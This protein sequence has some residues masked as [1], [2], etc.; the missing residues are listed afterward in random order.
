MKKLLILSTAFLMLFQMRTLAQN[1]GINNDGSQPDNS[2]MLDL[3]ATNKGLLIPRL[4]EAERIAIVNPATGLMVFQTD[5]TK[6]FYYFETAWKLVGGNSQWTTS[7]SDIYYNTGKVGIGTTSATNKL[8]I[9]ANENEGI[10]IG[11]P[12]D[13][14]GS[15]GGSYNIKFYGYSDNYISS[16]AAKISADRIDRWGGEWKRQGTSLGFYTTAEITGSYGDFSIERMRITD[17]GN[18]GIGK[19]LPT[20]LLDVNGVITAT[21]GNSTSWNTAYGW[22]PHAGSYRPISW[23]PAWT[24]VTSNPIATV[25]TSG[26]YNDLSD[27]PTILNSQ[28]TTSG[29]DLY[30]STGKVGIGT[31]SFTDKLEVAASESEGITIGKP[32]DDMGRDGGS[33]SIKFYGFRDIV[34]NVISAKITADRTDAGSGWLSQGTSLG[35]YTSF[36]L[37]TSNADNSLERMRITDTGSV[38]IGTSAPST[39]LDVN[40]VLTATGGNSGNWNTAFS[41]GNH[42]GLYKPLSYVPGWSSITDKPTFATVATTGSYSDLSIKPANATTSSNGFVS[43]ADKNKLNGLQN[44]DGSETKITAG[45]NVTATG[46]GTAINPFQFSAIA[47]MTQT[48]RSNLTPV[49][50]QIIYNTSTNKPN[51]YNGTQWMAFDGTSATTPVELGEFYQGGIVVYFFQPGN[52]G[53]IAGETHGLIVSP[54]DNAAAISWGPIQTTGADGFVVGDGPTNTG[55]IVATYGPGVYA[56]S[57]CDALTLNGYSDWYLPSLY[58]LTTLY[59]EHKPVV[60]GVAGASYWSSSEQRVEM[61]KKVFF[62]YNP[63]N[64]YDTYPETF[65]M[66]KETT[67]RVRAFRSF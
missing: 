61:A 8:E 56:A 12:Y 50:G 5:G 25:A 2:A 66:Q 22:G 29:S 64:K 4:T 32:N 48:Q 65:S 35:F 54:V 58:E 60:S 47:S 17:D 55:K 51:Y 52:P 27:K 46:S 45:T 57:L 42:A 6:G 37:G 59:H 44:A 9:A 67:A 14:M 63:E 19:S 49:A 41:W 18:V 16:I 34:H 39:L 15:N 13:A 53:Y 3:K 26:S 43:S 10:T 38:G 36:I 28:W 24:D 1:V 40:G 62:R 11:K 33:Y 7:G 23:L 21:E 20:T 30:Y 31:S